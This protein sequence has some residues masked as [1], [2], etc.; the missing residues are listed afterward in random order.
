MR[1][2]IDG[3]GV[4]CI[5]LSPVILG[6]AYAQTSVPVVSPP[7]QSITEKNFPLNQPQEITFNLNESFNKLAEPQQLTNGAKQREEEKISRRQEEQ[8]LDWLLL[9]VLSNKGLSNEKISRSIHDFPAVRYDFM[10]SF[11]K[12][13]YGSTRSRY[14]GDGK[15][16]ALVLKKQS[17]EE[18][19]SDLANIAD[20]HRKNLN[21]K[22]KIIEVFEY[23]MFSN[24]QLAQIT[25]SGEIDT[26]KRFSNEYGYYETIITNQDELKDFLSKTD[27]ITFTQ[28]IDSGLI[29]GGRKIYRGKDSPKYQAIK[30]EDI[31]ALYQARQDIDKKAND[32]YKSD[33]YQRWSKKTKNMSD[34]EREIADE[35]L[36]QEQRRNRIVDGSGFSLDWEYNYPALEKSLDEAI[37]LLRKIR[38]NGRLVINEQNIKQ[39]KEG[40]SRKDVEAFLTLTNKLKSVWKSDSLDKIFTEGELAVEIKQQLKSYEA[41]ESKKN[42]EIIKYEKKAYEIEKQNILNSGLSPEEINLKILELNNQFQENERKR[43]EDNTS[44]KLSQKRQLEQ[45][46]ITDNYRKTIHNFLITETNTR[47]QFARYDGDLIRGTEVGMTLFYTDLL[48]KIFSFNFENATTDANIEGFVPETRIPISQ[49]YQSDIKKEQF[50]RLWFEPSENGHGGKNEDMNFIFARNATQINALASN[51]SLSKNEVTAPPDTTAFINWWNNHYQEVARYEPQYERLNQIMKWNQIINGLS[52]FEK[53]KSAFKTNPLKFLEVVKINRNNLF[54]NWVKKQ[55]KNLK[56]QKWSKII[57]IPEGYNDRGKKTEKLKLL[58]SEPMYN[59]HGQTTNKVWS[60]GVSLGKRSD[61]LDRVSLPKDNPLDDIALRSNINPQKTIDYTTELK[62]Q[63]GESAFKTFENTNIRIKTLGKNTSEIIIEPKVGTKFRNLDAELNQFS[64]FKAVPESTP[65]NGLKL[66]TRLEDAKGVSTEFGEFSVTKTKNGFGVGFESRDID[67]GYSLASDLSKHKGDIPTFLASRDDVVSFSYS[68]S[69]KDFYV[70]RSDSNKWLKLSEGSGGG[71]DLP[72]SQPMMTVAEPGKDARILKGEFVDKAQVPGYAQGFQEFP[73]KGADSPKEFTPR[74]KAQQLA[75]N[76]LAFVK[77]RKLDL[78]LRKQNIDSALKN[79][80]YAKAEKLVNES[81]TQHGTDPELMLRKASIEQQ[82]GRVNIEIITQKGATPIKNNFFD[83]IKNRNF[84][85]IIETDTEFLYV[86]DS[87]SL[88][89]LEP[90][91]LIEQSLSSGSGIKRYKLQPGEVGRVPISQ[92]GFGDVT[93][94]SHPSTQFRGNNPAN[95]LKNRHQNSDSDN[96]CKNQ[97]AEGENKNPDCS[98]KKLE[99]PVSVVI[100]SEIK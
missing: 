66:I 92:S 4:F 96:E 89:N 73:G 38:L 13:E 88:N 90:A 11:T 21:E 41:E 20:Y 56:F 69:H 35:Q 72:P 76:P 19:K 17:P 27:D 60:G 29:L 94:S 50:V 80:D 33:F 97:Q 44:E 65:N 16:V 15:V 100:K 6:V 9:T 25:R 62:L 22:P 51:N 34:N 3:L 2:I 59:R 71:N 70:K 77:S 12:F 98:Q 43:Q 81:I 26:A 61:F 14:I 37:P 18:R 45:N 79:K 31:A 57:F 1:K 64:K 91:K 52:F 7:T 8:L 82:R 58:D 63:K 47:F 39:A 83:E 40:L 30:V 55:G 24:Q 86:Q 84:K 32:F 87:P 42:E 74:Q 67:A 5:A 68:Q 93:V 53:S 10:K 46:K 49:I 95:S 36:Y 99:K 78:Q 28:V 54:S 48:M 75:E 23:E 85:Q